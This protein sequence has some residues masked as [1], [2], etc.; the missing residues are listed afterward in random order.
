MA[1][2][3]TIPN[4]NDAA[5][6]AERRRIVPWAP[7]HGW[8]YTG[9]NNESDHIAQ[10][11]RAAGGAA[12]QTLDFDCHGSPDMFDHTTGSTALQFGKSLAKLPGFSAKTAVYLDGCNTGL[13]HSFVPVP[14]AQ[15]VADGARCTVYGTKGYMKG[16]YAEGTERCFA[17]PD[18]PPKEGGPLLA[19]TGAQT[20]RGRNV[21][22]AFR[23]IRSREIDIGESRSMTVGV[24]PG[25]RVWAT[26]DPMAF[27]EVPMTAANS[28]TIQGGAQ[29]TRAMVELLEGTM[30]SAPVEFPV[31]RMAPDVTINYVRDEDATIL[32]VYANGGLLKDRVTGK[33]WRVEKPDELMALVRQHLG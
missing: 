25:G 28:I 24:D 8:I 6:N 9:Y 20:A 26:F 11:A 1:S 16:T 7:G 33:A 12:I 17:G 29:V 3:I 30:R 13:T 10:I 23:P 32:D 22:I 4:D 19:Y 15:T 2:I 18:I 14:I 21:W 27:R 5:L 31:F